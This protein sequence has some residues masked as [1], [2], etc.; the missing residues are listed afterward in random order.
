MSEISMFFVFS[1]KV[2]EQ[3]GTDSGVT[4]TWKIG[5]EA[6]GSSCRTNMFANR[7]FEKPSHA[8]FQLNGNLAGWVQSSV[9]GMTILLSLQ[10]STDENSNR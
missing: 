6:A 9:Q 10:F 1:I 2:L 8:I 4:W 3:S 5:E 7:I